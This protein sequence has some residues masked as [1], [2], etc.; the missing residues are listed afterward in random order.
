MSRKTALIDT[1]ILPFAA[2]A[3]SGEK[4]NKIQMKNFGN[5]SER[6]IIT[7]KLMQT[8]VYD[9]KFLFFKN[10]NDMCECIF[11]LMIDVLDYL[12]FLAC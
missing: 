2:N 12:I 11:F 1:Y 3:E 8:S 4:S 6:K 10:E 5:L 9:K 7:N